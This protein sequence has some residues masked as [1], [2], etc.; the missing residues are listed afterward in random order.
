[1][2]KL[3]YLIL[4]LLLNPINTLAQS[5]SQKDYFEQLKANISLNIWDRENSSGSIKIDTI[6]YDEIPKDIDFRGT[7]VEA[8]KWDDQLGSNILIQSISGWFPSIY[9]ENTNPI[10]YTVEDKWEIYAYLF[11]RK[12]GEN[13]Y[14]RLWKVY[15]YNDCFGV[16]SYTGFIPKGTTIT[17][18]DNNGIAEVSMPYVLVCRGGLDPTTMKII[19]YEG[20]NKY[21]IRGETAIKLGEGES[22]G[23]DYSLSDNL[24][25]EITFKNFLINR[26]NSHKYENG[27]FY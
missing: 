8:L 25:K 4:I 14:K 6:S 27:R 17:D 20:N 23:G 13:N 26:W 22:Y 12:K 10:S 11:Q 2:T 24:N 5:D 1:M 19:M 3:K 18:I 16:D 9:Y 21:A 7:V 15:D